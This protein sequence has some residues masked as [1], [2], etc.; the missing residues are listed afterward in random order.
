MVGSVRDVKLHPSGLVRSVPLDECVQSILPA[1]DSNDSG[2]LLD[3]FVGQGGTNAGSGSNKEDSIIR[4]GHN[5]GT[6]AKGKGKEQESDAGAEC[7]QVIIAGRL[8][9]FPTSTGV[10]R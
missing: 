4:R 8:R 9:A 10:T 1:A 2:A 5:E 3:E 6:R 7:C